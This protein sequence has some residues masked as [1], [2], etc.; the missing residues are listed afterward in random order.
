MPWEGT[1]S[2]SSALFK[3]EILLQSLWF[4]EVVFEVQVGFR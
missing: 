3:L 2:L 1:S 4:W